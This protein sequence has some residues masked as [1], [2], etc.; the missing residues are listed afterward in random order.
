MMALQKSVNFKKS[1]DRNSV[2]M[3]PMC[4]KHIRVAIVLFG[5]SLRSLSKSHS[6]RYLKSHF[7]PYLRFRQW[8][9]KNLRLKNCMQINPLSKVCNARNRKNSVRI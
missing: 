2:S 3:I 6:V 1:K 9:V 8:C 4:Y 7:V 5:I